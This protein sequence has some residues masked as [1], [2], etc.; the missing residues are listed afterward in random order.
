IATFA[1]VNAQGLFG[2]RL[3]KL[4]GEHVVW[5]TWEGKPQATHVTYAFVS[6]RTDTPDAI[7]CRS[8]GPIDTVL[9]ASNLDRNAF[10]KEV[11]AAFDMWQAV[12]N[13]RFTEVDDPSRAGILIGAQLEPFGRAFA[14]VA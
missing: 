12:A 11:R 7:N 13:I 1:T 8:I 10:R 3:L 5:P 9:E 4:D 2:F 14:N 6:T